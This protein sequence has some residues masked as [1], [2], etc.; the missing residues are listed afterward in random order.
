MPPVTEGCGH[1]AEMS[2][3]RVPGPCCAQQV[4]GPKR[5]RDQM[6]SHSRHCRVR[7]RAPARRPHRALPAVVAPP[8][9]VPIAAPFTP[10]QAGRAWRRS[11]CRAS[12]RKISIWPLDPQV[13]P[14]ARLGREVPDGQSGLANCSATAASGPSAGSRA[15]TRARQPAAA[16]SR[17]SPGRTASA[18]SFCSTRSAS[19]IQKPLK[20]DQFDLGFNMRYFAGA[21]AALG[22]PKGGIDCPPQSAFR[23]GFPRPVSFGAP[24]DPHRGRRGCQGRPHEH[25]HRI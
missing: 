5:S 1:D 10:P 16:C 9:T 13:G 18:T 14:D 3:R 15:D 12:S 24:A 4:P 19:S 11:R 21:D 22:A 8:A 2:A 6:T 25:N 23:P 7:T 20:Q 17:S